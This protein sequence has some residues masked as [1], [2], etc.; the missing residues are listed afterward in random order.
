MVCKK[1]GAPLPEGAKFCKNCG[2]RTGLAPVR[3]RSDV[4]PTVA[5]DDANLSVNRPVDADIAR[6]NAL[7]KSIWPDWTVTQKLGEGSF[8]RVYRAEREDTGTKF[9]SAIKVITIPQ[10][11]AQLDSVRSEIGLDDRS[12]T[13][14]FQTMVNDCVNE[15][16]MM[17]SFKGTQNIVSVEDYK[18]IPHKDTIGWTILIRMELLTSFISYSKN[19]VF[20]EKEVIKLGIDICNALEYCAKLDVM[21]RD[22][23]PENIFV[24]NFGDF[25]LGDFGIARKLERSNNSMSRKGTYNYMAPEIYNGGK[26]DFKSDIYSLGIVLYKLM[27]NNRFPLIDPRVQ[28]VTYQ[29]M[30]AAFEKRMAGAAF[31]KPANASDAFAAV[32]LSACAFNPKDRFASAT[33]LKQALLNVQNGVA[34]RAYDATVRSPRAALTPEQMNAQTVVTPVRPVQPVQPPIQPPVKEKPVK[35]KKERKKMSKKKKALIGILVVLILLVGVAGYGAVTYFTS[36]EYKVLQALDAGDYSD[37]A[38]QYSEDMNDSIFWLRKWF[39]SQISKDITAYRDD[40]LSGAMDKDKAWNALSAIVDMN[41]PDLSDEAKAKRDEI[42]A[43]EAS[44]TA[45]EKAEGYMNADAPGKD[46]YLLAIEQYKLVKEYDENYTTAQSRITEATNKYRDAVLAEAQAR[47][48]EGDPQAARVVIEKG[49][50]NLPDDETLTAKYNEYG[51]EAENRTKQ[52]I[53]DAAAKALEENDY[54]TAM[55][56]LKNALAGA[57]GDVEYTARLRDYETKYEQYV[58]AQV[59]ELLDAKDYNG[60]TNVLNDALAVLPESETLKTKL[61]EVNAGKPVSLPSEDVVLVNK[62]FDWA[63][64]GTETP[65]DPYGT[66]YSGTFAIFDSSYYSEDPKEFYQQYRVDGK[67]KKIT[68]TFAPHA[69]IPEDG[70]ATIQIYVAGEDNQDVLVDTPLKTINRMTDGYSFTVDIT[71]AKWVKIVVTTYGEDEKNCAILANV[72]LWEN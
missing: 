54:K 47:A 70:S 36:G 17:E 16:K 4:E 43:L 55:Q 8:G 1:C 28:A 39:R 32:I 31:P 34:G 7:I 12:T 13:S 57:P 27:N 41:I 9:S 26:Y 25:K 61:D 3:P 33:A 56:T 37:A 69:D 18:V 52:E 2:E 22:I 66:A 49:L 68:G 72:Q 71:G 53:L 29:Q 15:I 44:K 19:K 42:D 45:F 6:Q 67:Y 38:A 5:A 23:K 24:S 60:A 21:H 10:N 11:Q 58:L 51:A 64:A 65:K 63:E 20:T 30:Q 14:Y 46:D 48:D 40:Y 50:E 59:A 62:N 35:E